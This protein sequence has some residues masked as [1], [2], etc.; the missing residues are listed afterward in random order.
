[1]T[2]DDDTLV[3]TGIPLLALL[4]GKLAPLGAKAY[5]AVLPR[6]R[7]RTVSRLVSAA[8]TVTSRATE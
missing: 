8:S 3:P 6:P 1:M 5:R 7:D 2:T 4:T